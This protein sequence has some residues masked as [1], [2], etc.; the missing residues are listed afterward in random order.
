MLRP[1]I[2]FARPDSRWHLTLTATGAASRQVVE[3]E[4]RVRGGE[5]LRSQV[6]ITGVN[7][8]R[9]RLVASNKD[10]GRCFIGLDPPNVTTDA[11]LTLRG[12][13]KLNA[14]PA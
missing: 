9:P 1:I 5:D 6:V 3:F 12:L 13:G 8:P 7:D 11:P 10:Q 2:V 4:D 14:F